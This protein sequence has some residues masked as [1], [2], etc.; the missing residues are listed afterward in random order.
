M[1][2][3]ANEEVAAPRRTDE[4][5]LR[6]LQQSNRWSSPAFQATYGVAHLTYD[7]TESIKKGYYYCDKSGNW[8]KQGS[9]QQAVS[10]IGKGLVRRTAPRSL[11]QECSL[12]M[13]A[14][15]LRER[16][17]ARRSCGLRPDAQG[18]EHLPTTPCEQSLLAARQWRDPPAILNLPFAAA[19]PM[20]GPN[21]IAADLSADTTRAPPGSPASASLE[22][23]EAEVGG[24]RHTMVAI[25]NN[26]IPAGAA[27][28]AMAAHD[29]AVSS[30]VP[31]SCSA[32]L[33]VFCLAGRPFKRP[34]LLFCR[35]GQRKR[36][37]RLWLMRK[38][39]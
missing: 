3:Q 16:Q 36:R 28:Q 19:V 11:L 29:S 23:D 1:A 4:A 9:K 15:T 20:A 12:E 39:N 22:P 13:R 10:K 27:H 26:A 31:W 25:A 5:L 8:R 14:H 18:C 38:L 33:R 30:A 34:C 32:Q 37:P 7:V 2:N 6:W 17:C 35:L 24:A 21:S